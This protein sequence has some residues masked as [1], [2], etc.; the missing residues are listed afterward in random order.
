[1][2]DAPTQIGPYAID[3]E[4]GRGGMGVVYLAR[5]TKLDRPVAIK[6]LP[7][8]LADDP[9]RL[10]RFEREARTLAQL[11]HLNVAGIYGVEESDGQRFLVLEYVEG[12]TL[13]ERLDRGPLPVDEA[14]EACAQ[15]AAGVEAAHEAGV[16][17][18]DLKPANIKM[19][20]EGVIKVLDFGLAKSTEGH[21]S[22]SSGFS[23]IQTVTSPGVAH[24]PT[25][26]GVILGTAPYMSP[27]QARGRTVDKRTDIWSFGVILYECLTGAGPFLGETATDSIGA[28]LHK[29]VDLDRL[30]PTTPR[31]IRHMLG[32]CLERDRN[33]RLRDIG[34]ARVEL[35][36]APAAGEDAHATAH[37]SSGPGMPA[38]GVAIVAL[39]FGAIAAWFGRSAFDAPAPAEPLFATI[40]PAFGTSIIAI[41]DVAG[42]AVVAPEGDTVVFTARDD[43]GVQRLW[44]RELGSRVPTPLRGTDGATFPFWSPDGRAVAFFAAGELR[45]HDIATRS[46]R[47]LCAAPGGRGG[48]WFPSGD[49]IFAPGFQSGIYRVP[50]T[51]GDAQPVTTVDTA[52]HTTH[53]WP[54]V[55][56]G[57]SRFVYLAV[58][59]DPSRSAESHLML[60]SLDGSVHAELIQTEFSAQVVGDSLLFLTDD[61]LC[62]VGF[63]VAEGT[64]SGDPRPVLDD[65]TG[66]ATTWHSLISASSGGALVFHPEFRNET[67]SGE[68]RTVAVAG[69][70]EATELIVRLRDGRPVNTLAEGVLQNS[71]Q[72]SP[73]GL[74]VA[75]SG[76]M[77]DSLSDYDIW[78]YQALD[79]SSTFESAAN[80]VPVAGTQTPRRLTFLPGAEV[81][82]VWSPDGSTIAF[83]RFTGEA[84][85]GIYT[86][87]IEG[88]NPQ[89]LLLADRDLEGNIYPTDW[90]P[91]G[92]FIVYDKGSFI[93][94]GASND[95]YA[96]PAGGG[97]P[98]PLRVGPVEERYGSV[99]PDGRWLSFESTDTGTSEVYVVPFL[100]GWD[101]ER[102]AGAAV[103]SENARW[104]IS[105]A[106]GRLP[107][108]SNPG[109]ELFYSS[110]SNSLIAVKWRTQDAAFVHDAGQ[111]LFDIVNESGTDYDVQRNGVSFVI[112]QA[113]DTINTRLCLVLN[114]ERLLED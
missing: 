58:H 108:W 102:E 64:I 104:R 109:D 97:E 2:S 77:P 51:G 5:D 71:L 72:I 40:E 88:G 10:A 19:T 69:L 73:D 37:G 89:A 76:L 56:D 39:L 70:G 59:H 52:R 46:T 62:A 81:S 47:T 25:S 85:L 53:R 28:I 13:A 87:P 95:I 44:V 14:L 57:T 36:R 29:D 68:S 93:G 12:E 75:I 84:E 27:E 8:H 111:A 110:S 48:S 98:L 18:R 96:I 20:P 15:I 45:R 22:S 106:G 74:S 11:S 42:P 92:R 86:I 41:G 21:S 35:E 31:M 79:P 82:P 66:D 103:P 63:D 67:S 38:L 91:D 105:L 26:P 60:G 50:D 55:I 99:S 4:I 16:I 90:T 1:M 24:S 32:R 43:R 54:H 112:N 6:A 23:Q 17:H 101:A 107:R 49:I 114:W 30:P 80:L 61:V 94:G 3:R 65:V 34:D 7:E 33:Q 113:G 83:G 9:E 78:V 100:P